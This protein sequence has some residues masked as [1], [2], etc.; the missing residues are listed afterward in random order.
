MS[1][2][3]YK[4]YVN[5]YFFECKSEKDRIELNQ[6]YLYEYSDFSSSFAIRNDSQYP[7]AFVDLHCS[8]YESVKRKPKTQMINGHEVVA[9]I[10]DSAKNGEI[11]Y[12]FYPFKENGIKSVVYSPN[13]IFTCKKF[14]FFY[15]KERAIAYAN[16]HRE[17]KQL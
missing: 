9:P 13:M 14:G 2:E 7:S 3:I 5:K 11:I 12:V 10:Y 15:D 1:K 8:N 4:E 6:Q 16:A 17:N